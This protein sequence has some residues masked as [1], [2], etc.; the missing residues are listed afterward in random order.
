MVIRKYS[1]LSFVLNKQ[2]ER[3]HRRKDRGTRV[4]FFRCFIFY[5]LLMTAEKKTKVQIY[6]FF[7]LN[8]WRSLLDEGIRNENFKR[9]RNSICKQA[10]R[11][12]KRS[13]EGLNFTMK[14]E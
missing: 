5:I 4:A 8:G 7:F 1:L 14:E 12:R 11:E 6:L 3:K 9:M 10:E 13:K 2:E